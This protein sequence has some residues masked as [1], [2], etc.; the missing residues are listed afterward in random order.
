MR[1]VTFI[2][3]SATF[4]SYADYGLYISEYPSIG[5]AEVQTKT[6]EIPGRDG[7][8]YL[9]TS[10]DGEVH[11]YNRTVELVFLCISDR[12]KW[13]EI[14][15]DLSDLLHGR[16]IKIILDDDP[17]Y[18]Y[19]GEASVLVPDYDRFAFKLTITADCDPYKY[20][21]LSSTEYRDWLWDD[22]DLDDGIERDY[23]DLVIDGYLNLTVLG[24]RMS[25][26]PV[27]I[28]SDLGD[29]GLIVEYN[30]ESYDLDEGENTVLDIRLSEGEN[31]LRFLGSG[32]VTIEYRGG[33]L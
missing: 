7:L 1:G 24:R 13:P 29:G 9:T 32:T 20:E 16:E 11:Y 31:V 19:Q 21:L 17:N 23:N 14:Y 15:S 8:L 18:Y 6:V 26:T 5:E 10:L 30:G 22:F 4:H 27:F 25:V 12:S 33:R 2:T 3:D 28:V